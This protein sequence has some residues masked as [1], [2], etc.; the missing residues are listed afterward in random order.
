MAMQVMMKE[1]LYYGTTISE[2]NV[3]IDG[4]DLFLSLSLSP[5]NDPFIFCLL[6][7]HFSLWSLLLS[8]ALLF[9]FGGMVLLYGGAKPLQDVTI[10]MGRVLASDKELIFDLHVT[11]YNPNG[12]TVHVAEAD[13][14]VFAF[15]RIVPLLSP[16]VYANQ[17]SSSYSGKAFNLFSQLTCSD[18]F[19][20]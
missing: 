1:N 18:T 20:V 16:D 10:S 13:I 19:L 12:W 5:S 4:K 15:S 11:A 14:S 3:A 7:S 8:L 6:L 17:S 2:N 9:L